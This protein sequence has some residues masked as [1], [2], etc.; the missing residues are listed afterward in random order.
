MIPAFAI[1]IVYYSIASWIATLSYP[2]ILSNSSMHTT[3]PSAK[4]IAPPS[5]WNS[6]VLGSL[7]TDAVRPAAEEPF[8]LV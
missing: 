6:P 3:P 5:N 1:E 8:P 2:L 7:I 4:T